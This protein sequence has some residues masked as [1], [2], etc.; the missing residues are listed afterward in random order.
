MMLHNEARN[1]M[2]QAYEKNK[3]V[4]RTAADFS[5]STSTVYRLERQMKK[6]GSVALR[7]HER[8]RKP[9]LSEEERKR[10]WDKIQSQNDIT[11]EEIREN[12][13]LTASYST[14]ERAVGKM[15]FTIKKKSVHASERERLRCTGETGGMGRI[16]KQV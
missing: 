5:V 11:I 1:L 6:T 15:G 4:K 10:I 12:L 16:Q 9:L 13:K 14:V 8:G 2:V 3:D 7:V